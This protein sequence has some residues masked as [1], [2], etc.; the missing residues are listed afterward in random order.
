MTNTKT[1]AYQ[2]I[3]DRII[4][5]LDTGLD[6]RLEAE[7]AMRGDLLAS[8]LGLKKKRSNGRYDTSWGDK[9]ALGL[10]LTVQRIIEGE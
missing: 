3:T 10:F 6:T 4:A 5:A 9:T 8:V 1:D 7:Q 2:E